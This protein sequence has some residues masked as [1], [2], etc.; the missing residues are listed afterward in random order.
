MCIHNICFDQKKEKYQNFSAENF[1]LLKLKK[2]CMG[3]F[4]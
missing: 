3:K 1:Q 4:S 2:N